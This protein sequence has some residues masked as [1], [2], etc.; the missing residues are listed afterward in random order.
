MGSMVTMFAP[1]GTQGQVPLDNVVDAVKA[2]GKLGVPLYAPDGTKGFVP[3]DKVADALHAG[4]TYAPPPKGIIQTMKDNFNSNTQGAKPGDGAVKGFVENVGAGGRDVIRSIAHP[5]RTIQQAGSQVVSDAQQG[6]DPVGR[7]VYGIVNGLA[8]NPG[9]T[10][11]QLGT[12]AIIGEAA[13]PVVGAAVDA[14][15]EPIANARQYLRPK[16]SPA[17]V[18][19]EEIQA[20]KI[21]QSILPPGG[22]KTE[23][24]KSI[25]SEAP[26]VA[27]YAQRT[28]NPLNTQAEG[29]KAAQGVAQEGL[30]H[31]NDNILGPVAKDT[32]NLGVGKT[33]LGNSSTLGQISDE[34]SSLNKQVNT[35]KAANAGDALT[36]MAKKGGV[37]DQLQYLRSVLYDNLSSKTGISP[38]DLQTLREGYGGQFTMADSLES[39][40]NAR[41]TRTGQSAQG[42]Q[43][44]A[45]QVPTSLVDLPMKGINLMRGGEQAISD[46][47]FSSAMRDVQPQA[48]NH[49]MPKP[50]PPFAPTRNPPI[51]GGSTSVQTFDSSPQLSVTEGNVSA[52]NAARNT[53]ASANRTDAQ[54]E[55]LKSNELDQAAQD[56]SGQ[57]N[58]QAQTARTTGRAAWMQSGLDKVVQ[59]LNQSTPGTVN[60]TGDTLTRIAQTPE[61]QQLLINASDLTPGSP[62]MKNLVKQIQSLGAS[63]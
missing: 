48:P 32:V 39:A 21:A 14:A 8:T 63:K 28:N 31:F 1:D 6:I 15:A 27:E 35:A 51:R 60:I 53:A 30:A 57:R 36:I 17:I 18:A 34:I 29:L 46:R 2:G 45:G 54:T 4:G 58:R 42:Q 38:A 44:I 20:Q 47:Q 52:R 41:L 62:A 25:Q 23:L 9:R 59:H 33:D 40:Q 43:T 12:G 22:I 19:P 11:G 55:F 5:I 56:A 26:A 61:G 13:A 16:S 7:A 3:Q 50:P 49:P 24:V 10:I 37:M